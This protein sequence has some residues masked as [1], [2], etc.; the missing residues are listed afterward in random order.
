[1]IAFAALID[2][3][4]DLHR[5]NKLVED[6]QGEMLRIAVSVLHDHQ[7]AEDAVQN[8]LYGVA[9]SFRHVPADDRDAAHSYL[10]S[11]AKY[12]ALRIRQ[13]EQRFDSVALTFSHSASS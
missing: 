5:F 3:Q 2:N 11:C 9:V 4:D 8:A 1:M 10:L 13:T 7:L 12:A 6:Y